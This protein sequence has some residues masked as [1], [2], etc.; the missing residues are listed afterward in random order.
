MALSDEILKRVSD[1]I[2]GFATPRVSFWANSA[3]L[4]S[5]GAPAGLKDSLPRIQWAVQQA[6]MQEAGFPLHKIRFSGTSCRRNPELLHQREGRMYLTMTGS[7]VTMAGRQAVAAVV[8]PKRQYSILEDT[9]ALA[10]A[11]LS[12]TARNLPVPARSHGGAARAASGE[13]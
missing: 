5:V 8:A 12:F 1:H 7:P 6:D 9:R 13:V 10:R 3:W 2:A 4:R 11:I